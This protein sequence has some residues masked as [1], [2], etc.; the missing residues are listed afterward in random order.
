MD[1][2]ESEE[3]MTP[4]RTEAET[5]RA[6]VPGG[7]G[8]GWAPL[9]ILLA[10]TLLAPALL[11]PALLAGQTA[12][13]TAR[14]YTL[15]VAAESDDIVE[16]IRFG[17]DGFE[18]LKSIPVGSWPTE[19][20]GPHGLV[21]SPDGK[22]WYVSLAHV[23]PGPFGT[24]QK[25]DAETDELLGE[26]ELGMFP[27]TMAVSP[28]TGLLYVVNFN[29]HGDM[30]PSTISVVETGSMAEVARVETGV[31]PHGA[32]M[33]RRGARLYQVNMM[34]DELVEVDAYRMRILRRLALSEHAPSARAA[35]GPS[36]ESRH[37]GHGEGAD[38]P[39]EGGG[40]RADP[41]LLV[42]P[43]WVT[44]PT[45]QGRVYVAGNGKNVIFEVDLE[46]WTITRR[47]D[48]TAKG[49]YNIDVTPDG[50]LMAVTY[51]SDKAVGF[52][53][54]GTGEEVARVATL[55]PVPHGVVITPDGRYAFV[56][57]E[58]IGGEP[59]SVEAY[60][61]RTLQRVDQIEIAKQAGGIALWRAEP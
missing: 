6:A 39:P 44:P 31:M 16:K 34:D 49:P 43:T 21:V 59:G 51:K 11:T 41:D 26:A 50:K 54:L 57:I 33:D 58:G 47:W 28:S 38:D 12:G 7:R 10:L 45:P 15:Y 4:N 53:D 23:T 48:D 19:V 61:L 36:N 3:A 8:S 56:S 52:W 40:H 37:G 35:G 5:R 17:P 1:G 14:S 27:A 20:E 2:R 32:R 29:L 30:V 55:R 9:G 42:K 46:S 24:V 13:Q 60:D 25:Y 18:H 22:H